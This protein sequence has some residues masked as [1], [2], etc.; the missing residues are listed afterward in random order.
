MNA[1]SGFSVRIDLQG[2]AELERAWRRAPEIV[3]EEMTRAMWE[4]ET[5]AEREVK[6]RTPV[7]VGGGGGLKG[8]IIA[9]MPHVS[10]AGVLGVVGTPL[11]YAVPVELGTRPHMP[12]I[13]PLRDWV[14]ARLGIPEERSYGV[15]RAVAFKIKAHGTKGRHMFKEGF[16]AARPQIVRM[17]EAARRR[18]AERLAG[19]SSA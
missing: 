17:F 9:K 4:A 18:I 6:E 1:A 11:N 5:L 16:K 14:E 7:G 10:P 3:A 12:P 13:A 8:S 19:N 15:A 2:A